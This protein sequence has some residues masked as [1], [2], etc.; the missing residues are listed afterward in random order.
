VAPGVVT[1]DPVPAQVLY[2]E[3]I[4]GLLTRT[5]YKLRLL[6]QLGIQF[7]FVL[8]FDEVLAEMSPEQFVRKVFLEKLRIE[9]VV[10][11]HDWRFG[12]GGTGD[13]DA[14]VSLGKRYNFGVRQV[15]PLIV[16]GTPV[17]ST[18]VRTKILA[19]DLDGASRLLGRRYALFG[20]VTRGSGLGRE[21]GFRTANI[22]P[23]DRVLPPNGIYA[24]VVRLDANKLPAALYIGTSPTVKERPERTVEVH[25][26]DYQEQLYGTK[27][28]VVILKR[29]RDEKKFPNRESLKNQIGEDI[30]ETRRV[31]ND[32]HGVA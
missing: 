11:G 1:F 29:L 13:R 5:D 9:G 21:L 22:D 30:E 25:I 23:E 7:A 3:T 18:L 20:P 14:M 8:A 10:V 28:E 31:M 6:E 32:I 15:E 19:G 26:L 17:S 2:P 24:A 16:D 12:S 27:L 4:P